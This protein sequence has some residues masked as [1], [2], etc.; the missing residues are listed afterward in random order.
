MG[1]VIPIDGYS[2]WQRRGREA[3]KISNTKKFQRDL[4]AGQYV[5]SYWNHCVIVWKIVSMLP[6]KYLL[7]NIV[8]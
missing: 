5:L 6:L 7:L 2:E 1:L 8:K 4:V 3:G